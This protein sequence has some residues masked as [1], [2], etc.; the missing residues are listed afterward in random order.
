MLQCSFSLCAVTSLIR[1]QMPMLWCQMSESLLTFASLPRT[2]WLCVCVCVRARVMLISWSDDSF[3]LS[4]SR[5][6]PD[7]QCSLADSRHPVSPLHPPPSQHTPVSLRSFAVSKT[8]TTRPT[9]QRLTGHT[10]VTRIRERKAELQDV[11]RASTKAKQ[12]VG[13][14]RTMNIEGLLLI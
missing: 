4:I 8:T 3:P 13:K 7:E 11:L 6:Q 1:P 12:E 9:S 2:F 14:E 10:F 5:T